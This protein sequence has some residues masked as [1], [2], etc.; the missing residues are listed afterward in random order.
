MKAKGHALNSS[1]DCFAE[2]D[3]ALTDP[4]CDLRAPRTGPQE[5]TP[6]DLNEYEDAFELIDRQLA[7]CVAA[8][9][10]GDANTQTAGAAA[11]QPVIL[12]A[13]AESNH[14]A[15]RLA[16]VAPIAAA[17][18]VAARAAAREYSDT[19]AGELWQRPEDGGTPLERLVGAVQNLLWIERAVQARNGKMAERARWEQ[20]AGVF[21]DVRRLCDEFGLA[22]AC[23]RA[24]FALKAFENDRLD[25]LTGEVSEL[26]RHIR[27]DLHTCSVVP[28]SREHVWALDLTVDAPATLAFPLAHIEVAEAGRCIALGLHSA[29]AFHFLRAAECGRRPLARAVRFNLDDSEATDWTTT[30]T[31]LQARMVNLRG[32]PAGPARKA[33]KAFLGALLRDA[34]ELEEAARRLTEGTTFQECHATATWYA[35]R[36][37]LTRAAERVCEDRETLLAADEFIPRP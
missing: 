33:V 20:I 8:P 22:S 26:I 10:E 17:I 9:A 27:H 15:T 37:F 7:A 30:V 32:W 31:A 3:E 1:D 23:V 13:A 14:K 29:A 18:T 21:S 19:D 35:A 24:E 11:A 6:A 12:E 4:K 25:V 28:V 34:R 2:F 36:D 5:P 16:L